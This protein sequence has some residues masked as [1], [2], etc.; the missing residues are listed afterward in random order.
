MRSV[1]YDEDRDV[2]LGTFRRFVSQLSE[3][4]TAPSDP[5]VSPSQL[6]YSSASHTDEHY[7]VADLRFTDR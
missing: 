2:A 3:L 4:Q 7:T 1:F 6:I 5:W